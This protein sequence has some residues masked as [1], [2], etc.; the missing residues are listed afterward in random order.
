MVLYNSCPC[1]GQKNIAPA[2]TAEDYTVSHRRFEIWECK[3]CTLRFTQ[4][5]PDP[6]G[7]GSYYQSENY[8]SHSNTQEGFINKLYHKVRVRT[9]SQKRKLVEK[10]PSLLLL[11][12]KDKLR[13]EIQSI[14]GRQSAGY[15]LSAD[16]FDP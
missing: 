10:D 9:L 15:G 2:L 12:N 6:V 16:P 1:C 11:V 8:I 5:V 7:I 4:N 3:N 13:N 14:Y